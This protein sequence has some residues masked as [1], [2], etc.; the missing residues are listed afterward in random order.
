MCGIH[1]IFNLTRQI[2]GCERNLGKCRDDVN[3]DSC[4]P[5]QIKNVYYVDCSKPGS[6]N[7]HITITTCLYEMCIY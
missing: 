6:G 7:L 1:A 5:Y 3:S 4:G 2:E